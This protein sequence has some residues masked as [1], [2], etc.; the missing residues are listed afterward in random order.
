[1]KKHLLLITLAMASLVAWSGE[2]TPR[3]KTAARRTHITKSATT[4]KKQPAKTQISKPMNISNPIVD[5]KTTM[6]DIKVRLYDDT[7]NHRD[8]FVKLASEGYYD[9]LLFH[10]VIKDFMVQ[11]GDP[12]SRNAAPDAMLGGGSP[13]YLI[14]AEIVYPKYWHKKG[15][16]AAARTNNPQKL[17]SGSQ[18]YIVTGKK[19][20]PETARQQVLQ[21]LQKAYWD[22][23]LKLNADTIK[24]LRLAHDR[25]GLNALHGELMKKLESEV[26]EAPQEIVDTYVN[27]GGTPWL[28]NEY[29]VFGEVI[30]GMDI[31]DKIQQVE[32]GTADRPKE[33]VKI[34]STK[35]EGINDKK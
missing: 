15:A 22:K 17:S 7:P 19:L 26:S 9:G 27:E 18:F 29:T 24:K 28:D 30:E 21:T 6:G 11:G 32:T 20:D 31:V 8:N 13:D 16:L 34:L 4:A 23:L 35:V 25:E 1:M 12:D 33:D 2:K 5:I 3:K 10:R 14:D